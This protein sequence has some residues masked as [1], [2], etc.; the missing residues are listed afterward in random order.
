MA[1][2]ALRATETL[3]QEVERGHKEL[4]SLIKDLKPK[5]ETQERFFVL[6]FATAICAL[7]VGI[8]A[9][10]VPAAFSSPPPN[11]GT[12]GVA[13]LYVWQDS[14]DTGQEAALQD[15]GIS[16]SVDADQLSSHVAYV[17]TFPASLAGE[18]FVLG[19]TGTA[20]LADFKTDVS[21][22]SNEYPDC[23]D[24]A[25]GGKTL[26]ATCQLITGIIPT[27]SDETAIGCQSNSNH[28]TV[29]VSFSGTAHVNSSFDWAHK[30]TSLPYL[31]DTRGAGGGSVDDLVTETFGQNFP[32][33]NLTSCYYL[34]L[35]PELTDYTPDFAPTTHVGDAMDWDPASNF[36]N[37]LVVSTERSAEW[38]GDL[39]LAVLGVFGPALLSS[40]GLTIRSGYRLRSQARKRTAEAGH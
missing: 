27:T 9:R 13:S 23:L 6:I 15:P 37:Y 19:I 11:Y 21:G 24:Q 3:K 20:V 5:E 38:K 16:L 1:E 18:R 4:T 34:G 36:A 8:S 2:E 12:D 17:A 10:L 39:L 35:D 40:L 33:A 7:F 30:I 26:P 29:S 32:A 14:L 22:V 25:Q 28:N 31:G